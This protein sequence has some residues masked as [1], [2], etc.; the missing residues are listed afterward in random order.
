MRK[1]IPPRHHQIEIEIDGQKTEVDAGVA[2]L[3]LALSELPELYTASSCECDDSDGLAWVD[4]NPE[5]G[6]DRADLADLLDALQR[7]L[8]DSAARGYFTMHWGLPGDDCP[9]GELRCDPQSIGKLSQCISRFAKDR[10]AK[11]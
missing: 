3:V 4:F 6:H 1:A 8:R 5:E 9:I 11:K 7:R 2:P 10:Q